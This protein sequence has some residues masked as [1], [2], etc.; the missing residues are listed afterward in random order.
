MNK[1]EFDMLKQLDGLAKV[2]NGG[3]PGRKPNKESG[4]FVVT[5]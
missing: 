1:N 3:K 5:P 4:A 2:L